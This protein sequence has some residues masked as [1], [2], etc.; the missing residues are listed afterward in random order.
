[1][2]DHPPHGVCAVYVK[3]VQSKKWIQRVLVDI[4]RYSGETSN[5]FQR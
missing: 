4:L 3:L 1:M 5:E 2:E